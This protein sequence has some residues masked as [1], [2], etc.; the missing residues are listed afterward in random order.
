P[1]E[2]APTW[3]GARNATE[4]PNSCWQ[5]IDTSFGRAQRVEMWNPNTNMSED[6]LY[7]NLWIPSTTTTKPILVW[8]YGG[9]FWAGTSTLSVYNALRLASRSDLI[10]ASF[11]Y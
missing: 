7:L 3:Q 1:P 9:G 5:M 11:N 2:A 6:C 4:M 10:V 8:I